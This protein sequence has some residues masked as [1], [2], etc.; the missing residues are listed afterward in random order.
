MLMAMGA[1]SKQLKQYLVDIRYVL[2]A[3]MTA[4]VI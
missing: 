3:P 1:W 4:A 2:V